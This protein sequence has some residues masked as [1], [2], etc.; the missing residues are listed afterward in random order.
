MNKPTST[1]QHH[2]VEEDEIDLIAL[3]KTFW[4]GRKTFIKTFFIF[5]SI[6]LFM[7]VFSPKQYSASTTIVVENNIEI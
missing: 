3:A 7:A 2:Y 6:G 4:N 5:L 1:N